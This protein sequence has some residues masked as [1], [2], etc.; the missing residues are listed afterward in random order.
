MLSRLTKRKFKAMCFYI[1]SWLLG[2]FA[3]ILLYYLGV[4]NAFNFN[5]Y[6]YIIQFSIFTGL[7]QGIYD[8]L[9]LQDDKDHRPVFAALLIRSLYL[10]L[11]IIINISLCVFIE[12]LYSNGS[13]ISENSL[14]ALCNHWNKAST[15]AFAIYAFLL[16]F[17]ITFIRSVHKKFGTRVLINTILG[18]YQD[19]TEEKLVFMFVDL[20]QS[21]SLAEE[22]GNFKYSNFLR[23]YYHYLSNCC[24]ENHGQI[25][26]IVGDGVVLTWPLKKCLRKPR[27]LLC[28]EDLKICFRRLIPFFRKKYGKV[29]SFRASAHCGKVIASEVGNF[30][31]E[32]AYHGDA[33]NT[34]ARLQDLCSEHDYEFLISEDLLKKLPKTEK[35]Q[36][37]NQGVMEIKG[38]KRNIFA[39]TLKFSLDKRKNYS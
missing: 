33:I 22:L 32:M 28:F 7:S 21:T 6:L 13:L 31:S 37:E 8:I 20:K 23:D 5:F 27:P 30:G 29:P 16:G 24:E 2:C 38:K 25:Y 26:Q 3:F 14:R 35:Y 19:P 12:F 34:T 9:I 18:K 15:C 39:Y 4:P 17:L 1:S 36:P 10:S 11:T